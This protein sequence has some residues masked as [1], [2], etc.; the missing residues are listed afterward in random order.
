VKRERGRIT[1]LDTTLRDGDQSPGFALS[2]A[3]K[4]EIA[5]LLERIGIDIIEAG[6]PASSERQFHDVR[7]IS[8]IIRGSTIAAMARAVFDDIEKAGMALEY[9]HRK[10][11]HTSIATSPI[12]RENKLRMSR[13]RI[14]EKAADAVRFARYFSDNVEMGAEDSTRTEPDFLAEFCTAVAEAGARVVNISDTVGYAQPDEFAGLIRYLFKH[15]GHFER[16]E[17]LLSVHC[18]NDLGSATANTL[19]GIIAGASR[20]ETTLFGIGER[21][22]NAALEEIVAAINTRRDLYDGIYT[23]INPMFFGEAARVLSRIYGMPFP[24]MKPVIGRNAS[25]HASGIHQNGLIA[26]P[27]TYTAVYSD[28]NKAE[29]YRFVVTR[30]S[31]SSGISHRIKEMTGLCLSEDEIRKMSAVIKKTADGMRIV[32]ATTLIRLLSSG[33]F[34][35]SPIWTLRG[36]RFNRSDDDIEHVELILADDRK[37]TKSIRTDSMSI[38][39]LC[40]SLNSA[41][42]VSLSIHEYHFTESG[43][44][45]MRGNRFYLNGSI[46]DREYHEE[47]FNDNA[48]RLFVLCYLDIINQEKCEKI[49]RLV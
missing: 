39:S 7:E 5:V 37:N 20:I 16:G 45:D 34:I 32:D 41:F 8:R 6:F 18:H 22:G 25:A 49:R 38:D 1:V 4:I 27:K 29:Q 31:G 33:G 3:E 47:R 24:P 36:L 23:G 10:I 11:I 44:S 26:D 35:R 19:A 17:C 2:T 48:V 15:V 21:A 42:G 46:D 40:V 30:H 13:I 9:A 14:I 43:N 12:H 28:R